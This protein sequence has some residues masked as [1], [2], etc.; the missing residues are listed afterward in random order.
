MRKHGRGVSCPGFCVWLLFAYPSY[1]HQA[2][3]HFAACVL[4][5]AKSFDFVNKVF[6][7]GISVSVII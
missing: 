2:I 1:S 4:L 7:W 3:C 6:T 5:F